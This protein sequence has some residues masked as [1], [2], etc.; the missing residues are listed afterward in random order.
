[1]DLDDRVTTLEENGG[2]SSVAELEERV[3]ALEITV[4]DQEIRLTAA[5]ENIQ[6]VTIHSI[7]Y[8]LVRIVYP[9]FTGRN[10]V[11]PRQYFHSRVSRILFTGGRGSPILGGG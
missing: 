2:N 7:F 1:M 5:E 6:G 9:F 8:C 11:G 10:E 4:E 3:E